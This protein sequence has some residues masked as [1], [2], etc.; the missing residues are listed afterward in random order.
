MLLLEDEFGKG[1]T[2]VV[3]A[4]ILDVQNRNTKV[5]YLLHPITIHGS[6]IH[7]CSWRKNSNSCQQ[8]PRIISS[9]GSHQLQQLRQGGHAENMP[10][11][12]IL[13]KEGD[14]ILGWHSTCSCFLCLISVL[15]VSVCRVQEKKYVL[16]L[17]T[18]V[19]IDISNTF[20]YIEILHR[21]TGHL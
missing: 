4:R 6:S 3:L 13:Q 12:R 21:I 20:K 7:H 11:D 16:S 1:C 8:F 19:S 9:I 15:I 10:R 2:D 14:E 18:L 17:G 5:T